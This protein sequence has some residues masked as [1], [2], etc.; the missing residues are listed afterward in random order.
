MLRKI[1]LIVSLLFVT[2]AYAVELQDSQH[3]VIT[4]ATLAGK[5]VIV[6]YWAQWC[7]ACAEETPE[8]NH[9]YE[10]NQQSDVLI[11]GVNF[12]HASPDETLAVSQRMG[13]KYPVLLQDPN[14]MWRL[15]AVTL[16]PTTFI[17]NP[18]GKV[19]EKIIGAHTEASMLA[20][21]AALKKS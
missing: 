20:I 11:Y 3:N 16:L 19:V 8:L 1:L 4:S 5:W 9:L 21:L 7:G 6:N 14:V 10:A 13:I 18:Q 15:G 12:D 17:I 2:Q